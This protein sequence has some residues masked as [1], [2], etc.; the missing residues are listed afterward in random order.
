[1]INATT[2][3][4][5]ISVPILSSGL[6]LIN[7]GTLNFGANDYFTCTTCTVTN[8][9][10]AVIALVSPDDGNYLHFFNVASGTFDNEG[11]I[12]LTGYLPGTFV[13][14]ASST[15][16]APPSGGFCVV[17]EGQAEVS[18]LAQPQWV[19]NLQSNATIN[20]VANALGTSQPLER[21]ALS[22]SLAAAA[23]LTNFGIG[24]CVNT[25]VSVGVAGASLGACFIAAPDGT[26]GVALN[27]VGN[28][29]FGRSG[30][31]WNV[32]DLLHTPDAIVDAGATAMWC[33]DSP[34]RP[35]PST[36]NGMRF[37]LPTPSDP[38]D[39]VNGLSYCENGNLTIGVGLVGSHC[40]GPA[41]EVPFDLSSV[42]TPLDVTRPGV[43][44]GY[45]GV[46]SGGGAGFSIG[47]SYSF[48]VTCEKWYSAT[49]GVC[50]P[51]NMAL[52]TISPAS[53]PAVG[54][55]LAASNGS[56]TLVPAGSTQYQYSYQWM[57]CSS[58][59]TTSACSS[60]QGATTNQYTVVA[61]DR[62]YWLTIQVTVQ[63]QGGATPAVATPVGQVA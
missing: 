13:N 27:V 10:A 52:P 34:T 50:P 39:D 3:V 37:H 59:S 44:S 14:F 30:N 62:G 58:T 56:W 1:V 11:L 33:V 47:M 2:T 60:I 54:Q 17:K 6:S 42:S 35:C 61:A 46:S 12:K 51:A 55:T 45:L 36:L 25:G 24:E 31:T 8:S 5:M 20:A 49:L 32:K 43:H 21:L 23:K 63:N 29:G 7:N 9:T 16:P 18:G 15:C 22:A 57:R 4:T 38:S 53:A 26:E 48:L 40:W 19:Q 28:V 41:N